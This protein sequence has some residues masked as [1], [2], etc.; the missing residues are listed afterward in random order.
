ML[1]RAWPRGW[2]ETTAPARCILPRPMD[3]LFDSPRFNES[4]FF[5]SPRATPA[6]PGARDLRVP[7]APG[8]SLH[9][10][11]HARA[12]SRALVLLFHGNGEVVADYDAPAARFADAGADLLVV[13]YRG[14]GASDGAPTL[15]ACLADAHRALDAAREAAA[16]LPLV[17]MGRSLGSA[18][19]AELCQAPRDGVAG[20]VFESAV[21]DLDGVVRRRGITL[22][23]PLSAADRAGFDPLPKLARCASPA[24]V[25]HGADDAL[26]PAAEARLAHDSLGA[27][28]KVLALVPG[29]GHNDLS[30]HPLYWESL[31]RF[32]ARITP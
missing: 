29:R 32:L 11:R 30:Q 21:A 3:S 14:Y 10:R 27:L 25:L 4:L 31:A 23:E 6:P 24:L 17:V 28:D 16:G 5:P 12:G 7:V 20:Y 1:P 18:C 13:D 8:L 9:A 19:A 22:G 2:C 26:I 15:R